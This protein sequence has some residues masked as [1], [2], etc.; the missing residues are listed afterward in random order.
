MCTLAKLKNDKFNTLIRMA[1]RWQ[2]ILANLKFFSVLTYINT[3][4][5]DI[6]WLEMHF[7]TTLLIHLKNTCSIDFGFPP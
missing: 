1:N 5:K 6:Q 7:K 4:S 3:V 2:A